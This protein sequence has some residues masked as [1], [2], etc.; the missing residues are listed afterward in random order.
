MSLP[1]WQHLRIPSL[2][3][4]ARPTC[5]SIKQPCEA[6]HDGSPIPGHHT[7]PLCLSQVTV[8]Q[9]TGG[10]AQHTINARLR[11]PQ[12]PYYSVAL[13]RPALI[14][15]LNEDGSRLRGSIVHDL[16]SGR[17]VFVSRVQPFR[18]RYNALQYTN[19]KTDRYN[20][21]AA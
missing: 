2:T 12:I 21:F 9:Y 20:Q 4:A 8:Q 19:Q 3:M 11:P 5:R 1:F 15:K 18:K 10:R 17:V 7:L 14:P 13:M 6:K 16:Q